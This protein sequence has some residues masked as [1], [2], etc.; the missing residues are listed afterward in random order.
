IF[1][2]HTSLWAT[3][4]VSADAQTYLNVLAS[5]DAFVVRPLDDLTLIINRDAPTGTI[6][7][8]TDEGTRAPDPEKMPVKM[9]RTY[10]GGS[11][12]ITANTAAN[13]TVVTSSNHGLVT[14][15]TVTITGS[16]STPS[17]DGSHVVTVT[18][19]NTFTVAVNVT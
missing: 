14:G 2:L 9:V 19:V 16:D 1:D 4:V 6:I 3:V 10:R 5:P 13:P 18:G 7:A 8:G 17:L 12:A 11:G 15:Q